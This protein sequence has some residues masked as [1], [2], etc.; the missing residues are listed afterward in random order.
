MQPVGQVP[1][2]SCPEP[3]HGC[4]PVSHDLSTHGRKGQSS[5][6]FTKLSASGCCIREGV[7]EEGNG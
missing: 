6:Q 5:V 1:T 4:T 2:H 3:P 7:S